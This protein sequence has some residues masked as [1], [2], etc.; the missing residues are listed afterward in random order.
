LAKDTSAA[1]GL[2]RGVRFKWHDGS[3]VLD[4]FFGLDIQ[5]E[6][7]VFTKDEDLSGGD[8]ASAPWSDAE[9]GNIYGTGAD[10]G[11]I[12][13]GITTDN[14]IDTTSGNLVIDSAGGTTTVD[15]N[16]VVSGTGTITGAVTLSDG[17]G[18]TVAQGG[19]GVRSFTGKSFIISN[20]GGTALNYVVN[21]NA[22]VAGTILQFN[23]A[24]EPIASNIIDGG[25]Y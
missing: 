24:N 11:N 9:F 12:Q 13:V 10:L 2:D 6:R 5:T 1:D 15:D 16:L 18:L 23:A 22:G 7:F 17:T 4:G 3:S 20:N 21:T 14:E 25:T 19:T 8:N